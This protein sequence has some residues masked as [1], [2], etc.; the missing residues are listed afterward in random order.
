MRN[1]E[2][3]VKSKSLSVRLTSEAVALAKYKRAYAEACA[4]VKQQKKKIVEQQKAT[5]DLQTYAKKLR[6]H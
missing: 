1:S 6:M 3:L 4:T 5:G 2:A